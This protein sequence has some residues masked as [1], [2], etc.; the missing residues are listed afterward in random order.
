MMTF[1]VDGH[2]RALS[3]ELVGRLGDLRSCLPRSGAMLIDTVLDTYVNA[4][5]ILSAY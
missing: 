5:G 4:L 1:E 3:I 2:I